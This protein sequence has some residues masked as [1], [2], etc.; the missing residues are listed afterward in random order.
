MAWNEASPAP[1]SSP[2]IGVACKVTMRRRAR[3]GLAGEH[4]FARRREPDVR[5]GDVFAVDLDGALLIRVERLDGHD[6]IAV[7]LDAKWGVAARGPHV[8][9]GAADGERAGIFDDGN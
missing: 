8:D 2:R 3:R 6:Q 1:V 4:A 9:Q 7:Q 5:E